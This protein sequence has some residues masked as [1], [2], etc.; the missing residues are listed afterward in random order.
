MLLQ[1]WADP[2]RRITVCVDS[3]ENGIGI[4]GHI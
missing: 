1:E 4:Y 3:Y 2:N